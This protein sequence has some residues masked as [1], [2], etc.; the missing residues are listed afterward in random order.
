MTPLFDHAARLAVRLR[1]NEVAPLLSL[2]GGSFFVWL[3]VAIAG[4]VREGDTKSF[5]TAILLGLRNPADPADPIGPRWFEEAAR[6]VTALGGHV[7]LGLVALS[8]LAYLILMRRRHAALLLIAA[9]GGGMLLSAGLKVG[10]ERPRPDLV[11][12]ATRVYTAS[13]PSGHSMLSA[14]TYLTLGALLARTHPHRRVKAFFIV[15][16]ILITLLVGAS[17]VYLGVH[18]PTDV[19]AGWCGGAAWAALCWFVALTLQRRGQVEPAGTT[20]LAPAKA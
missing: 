14:V 1:L 15:L 2:A 13:F 6:D 4:E 19:L 16:A 17:R 9:V 11:A 20:A 18:W 8:T 7:V 12:H 3:F 10:F 5:D